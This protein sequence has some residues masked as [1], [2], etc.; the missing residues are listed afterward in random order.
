MVARLGQVLYWL[1]TF[2]A[3]VTVAIAVSVPFVEGWNSSSLWLM[4]IVF[5]I[6]LASWLLGRAVLYVL[7]GR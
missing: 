3:I 5:A 7:A 1:A 6:A 2:I 4:A